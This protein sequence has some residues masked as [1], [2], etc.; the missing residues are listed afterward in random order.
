MNRSTPAG[1]RRK[2]KKITLL[3]KTCSKKKKKTLRF[4]CAWWPRFAAYVSGEE[5]SPQRKIYI[6]ILFT[7]SKYTYTRV[8]YG[9]VYEFNATFFFYYICGRWLRAEHERYRLKAGSITTPTQIHNFSQRQIALIEVA[10]VMLQIIPA[11]GT[12][13]AY[14]AGW[15]VCLQK[16]WWQ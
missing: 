3:V 14:N 10:K 5:E 12:G 6:C 1:K 16:R 15:W 7:I 2:W 9:E 8:I 11:E 4:I 13:C